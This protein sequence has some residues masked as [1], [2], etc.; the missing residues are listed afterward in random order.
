MK[1]L[2]SNRG[3]IAFRIIKTCQ[4]LGI[5]TVSIYTEADAL[6]PHV[7]NSTESVFLGSDP[8][9]YLNIDEIIKI[10]KD[11]SCDAIHPGYGFLSE[12]IHFVKSCEINNIVFLGPSI[13]TMSL[14]SEK[15]H[16]KIFAKENQIPIIKGTDLINNIGEIKNAAKWMGYPIMLKATGGG[17]GMGIHICENDYDVDR[18]YETA[19]N[20]G[21]AFFGNA[22]VTLTF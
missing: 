21:F 20:Q 19:M 18:T 14:F 3:E 13:E 1:L 16:A 10:A 2:I 6:S 9:A 8:K 22:N 12:N 7:Q 17:G 15:H 5:D 4:K 11:Q